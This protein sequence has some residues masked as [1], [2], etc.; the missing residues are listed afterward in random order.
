MK[1]IWK[2][3]RG[4]DKPYMISNLGNIKNC[5]TNRL[6]KPF[7]NNGGYYEIVLSI[8]NKRKHFRV[9]R[10]VANAFIENPFKYPIINHID[11]NRLNNKADNLEWCDYT[12]NNNYNVK[13]TRTGKTVKV[14]QYDLNMNYIRTFNRMKDIENKY[15]IS[16]TAIR[17]CCLGKN[18]TCC[19]YIWRYAEE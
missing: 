14:K 13:C 1:E 6:I 17:F 7:I 16:R 11:C 5:K 3:I 2:P 19:G 18:K 12:Y 8:N 9:H 10:L 4:L 15:N